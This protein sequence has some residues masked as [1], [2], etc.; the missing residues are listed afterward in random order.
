MFVDTD[1]KKFPNC[2]GNVESTQFSLLHDIAHEM[3]WTKSLETTVGVTWVCHR[4][5]MVKYNEVTL[6]ISSFYQRW[7]N[8]IKVG[9]TIAYQSFPRVVKTTPTMHQHSQHLP[10]ASLTYVH[11]LGP[12]W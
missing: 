3:F 11:Y 6:G 9:N 7:Y 10:K 1:K 4:H 12:N 2:C 5:R 8:K